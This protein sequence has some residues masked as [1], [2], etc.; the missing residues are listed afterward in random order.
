VKEE[1]LPINKKNQKVD[2]KGITAKH[3]HVVTYCF[4]GKSVGNVRTLTALKGSV[5][6]RAR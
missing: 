6:G 1:K 4:C 2:V 3:I 5:K